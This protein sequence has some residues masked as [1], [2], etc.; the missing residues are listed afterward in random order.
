MRLGIASSL[1]HESP[2]DWGKKMVAIGVKAVVFPVDF[3]AENETI[4][5]YEKAAYNNDLLIAEVGVWRNPIAPD[6]KIREDALEYAIGQLKLADKIGARCCVNITGSM[7]ERWDGAYKENFSSAA[8]KASVES[9]QT[10]IDAVKPTKTFYSIEPMPW[11]IPSDPDEY[12][13]LL[14]TVD[15]AGFAVHMD[16]CNW[17]TSPNKYF[18]SAHFIKE[19]FTKLG[20]Y[21][22]SCHLK[23]VSLGEEFTFRLNET[24]CGGG[25][26]DLE[27]YAEEANRIDSDM[28]MLIEHLHGDDE[29]L[30]SLEYTAKRLNNWL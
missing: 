3:R 6:K 29:Y 12:L 25:S 28:P 24:R 30:T 21:I 27:A 22:R 1:K 13:K 8:F 19:A 11:M 14:A 20:K 15:R 10:I 5:R 4:T 16:I 18:F 17:I 23:D 7:G 26:I 2:E 9:I